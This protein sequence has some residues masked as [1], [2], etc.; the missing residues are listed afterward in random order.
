M[1]LIVSSMFYN[2]TIAIWEPIIERS[3]FA[4]DMS[5]TAK[6]NPKK[7]IILE[8]NS[9]LEVLN[10]NLSAQMVSV[11]HRT[12]LSWSKE[13]RESKRTNA[14]KQMMDELQEE[15]R[16]EFVFNKSA[17]TTVGNSVY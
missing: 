13:L 12:Y 1:V 9:P 7:Y 6:S 5:L 2:P 10:I 17:K 15:E 14:R 4:L 3:S 8:M 11:F 16:K